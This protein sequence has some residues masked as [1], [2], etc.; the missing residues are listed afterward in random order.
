M[1][2]MIK[3]YILQDWALILV[4]VAFSIML[5]TNIFIDKKTTNRTFVLIVLVFLLSISVFIEFYFDAQ[6]TYK[7]LRLVLM[8]IR[9]SATP[10]I[11]AFVMF[12]LIKRQKIAIFI[13]ALANAIINFISIFTGIVF[14]INEDN[15]LERGIFGFLPFIMVGVYSILL[16]YLLIER[17]NK[18]RM[19]IIPILYLCA[20]FASG[21][22]FPFIFGKAFSQIFCTTV[23]IALF[24]YYVFQILTLTKKDSLTGLLNRLAYYSDVQMDTRDITSI[25]SLDMN[26]LKATNDTYGHAAGD[27]AL[28]AL[29][30]CFLK[31]AKARQSVYRIGGDEFVIVCRK[32]SK[33]ETVAL[34]DRI[35]KYVAETKYSCSI[36]YSFKTDDNKSIDDLL[37]ESD[38]MM[39]K[40]KAL[41]YEA[42][43]KENNK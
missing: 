8:A 42:L 15:S 17:S 27:E 12:T 9:Y 14:S 28:T 29:A 36:G 19:E 20:S 35:Y 41:H 23:A 43:R 13:P 31:A 7:N 32:T 24:A 5:A 25:I 38:D 40:N 39:Y 30:I 33:E 22:V 26:G 10:F 2:D 34:I 11:M 18:R 6:N 3:S 4:L 21:I 16:V 37:K 1:F